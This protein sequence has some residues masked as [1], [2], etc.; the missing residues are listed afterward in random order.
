MAAAERASV[1]RVREALAERGISPELV[2]LQETA[3]SAKEAAEA[4]G[5]RV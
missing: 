1:R 3:R 5:V 2:E 4:L